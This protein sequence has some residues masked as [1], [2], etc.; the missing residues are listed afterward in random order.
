[1]LELARPALTRPALRVTMRGISLCQEAL[2]GMSLTSGKE[3][4]FDT[5]S[6]L[7]FSKCIG[8]MKFD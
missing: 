2:L 5:Q 6:T 8:N 7:F 3:G 4:Y 1:M